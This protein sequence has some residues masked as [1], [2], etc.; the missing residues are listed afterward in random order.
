MSMDIQAIIQ[1]N[2]R[3]KHELFEPY[4][5]IQGTAISIERFRFYLT[6]DKWLNLPMS[7][8]QEEL[9]GQLMCF[10]SMIEALQA[11]TQDE[12]R[13]GE[14]IELTVGTINTLRMHHD[15]EFWCISCVQIQRKIEKDSIPFRLNRAQR[16]LLK[17]FEKHRLKREAILIVL[18]KA[19]QWGGSTMTQIYMSWL[20]IYHYENW[21][22]C[23]VADVQDQARNIRGMYNHMARNHPKEVFDVRLRSYE[24]S[25]NIK[26]VVDRG[27]IIQIGSMQKPEALRSFNFAMCHFSE[28]GLW[29]AT[30]SKTP[31]DVIQGI[32][33]AIVKA[34]GVLIVLESTAKGLGNYYHREWKAAADGR[35]G[36]DPVFVAW[37]EIEMYYAQIEDIESFIDQMSAYQWE[38][39]EQGAT[40][41]GIHWYEM[42]QASEQL[43]DWRMMSEFPG[44]PEEA[45]G[46]TGRRAF[47]AKYVKKAR[48]FNR[49]PIFTGDIHADSHSGK[50]ALE[51]LHFA[52]NPKGMLKIWAMPDETV[53][54]SNRYVVSVDI[55]GRTDKAD[56]S[57]IR[58]LDRAGVLEGGV[59]EAVLTWRG[60][61]D[62]D[63]VAWKAAQIARMYHDALLVPEVN[64]LKDKESDTEGEHL[65]TVLDEI[66]PFYPNVYNR[67]DPEKIAQGLP[68]KYGWHTNRLTKPALVDNMNKLLRE[69]G[70]V[71]ADAAVCDE[72]DWFEYKED[73]TYGAV[74]GQHDDLAMCTM[75]GCKVSDMMPA[76]ALIERKSV[77]KKE[78]TLSNF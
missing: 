5:P 47:S 55:G 43:D 66:V 8:K 16:K 26:Q 51:N 39:W 11:I 58:V 14:V 12:Q 42:H 65:I 50:Q 46:S 59:P 3:R 60:H 48:R 54:M 41:E 37:W 17:Q 38:Q 6:A 77:I 40:L 4:D 10:P 1:E 25:Q 61:L 30:E 68:A 7:M 21:H 69:D 2:E 29:K 20:Q 33:S 23:I 32:R 64:S 22:S 71:E 24:G 45:F 18:L 9:I 31:E 27:C 36:Y 70:Y 78:G 75:I 72:Y 67:T 28:V 53:K 57:T 74:S 76:P 62:Q 52:A 49:L 63:L 73:G 35:S 15:F 44:T 34:P 19:R 13:L 56:Y